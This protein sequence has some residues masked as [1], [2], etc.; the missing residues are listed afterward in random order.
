MSGTAR[1]K[2]LSRSAASVAW[3]VLGLS[4]VEV[5]ANDRLEQIDAFLIQHLEEIPVPGFSVVV[6]QGDRILF[7]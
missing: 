4:G 1:R 5:W 3:M 7:E 6:V 2:G